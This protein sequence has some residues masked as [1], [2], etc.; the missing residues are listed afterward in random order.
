MQ[1][2]GCPVANPP[3]RVAGPSGPIVLRY[4]SKRIV[5]FAAS[6]RGRRLQF[7]DD[8]RRRLAGRADSWGRKQLRELATAMTPDTLLPW[9]RQLITRKW[10]FP[11]RCASR[12]GVLTRLG[13]SRSASAEE[14]PTWG[15]TRIQGALKNVGH[16]VGRS[17]IARIL[18]ATGVPPYS[19]RRSSYRHPCAR[20][21]ARLPRRTSSRRRYGPSVGL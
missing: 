13:A 17:T 3:H 7:T 8:D 6:W 4:C 15:Y 18:K 21:G 2:S 16:R 19:E 20:T 9:H 11:T 14:K 12:G 10:T 1:R 5:C